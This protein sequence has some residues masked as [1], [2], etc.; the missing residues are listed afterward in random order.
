[1]ARCM[2][3]LVARPSVS[4]FLVTTE[5]NC[6]SANSFCL[7]LNQVLTNEPFC[8]YNNKYQSN[9]WYFVINLT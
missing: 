8:F 6:N 2:S 7:S 4:K 1:M 5:I 9:R 3:A